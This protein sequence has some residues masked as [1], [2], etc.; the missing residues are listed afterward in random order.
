[1]PNGVESAYS[2][3]F[4]GPD[5]TLEIRSDAR[6]DVKSLLGIEGKQ[7]SDFARYPDF[8]GAREGL[9]DRVTSS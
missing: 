3:H 2:R 7:V 6:H 5:S 4:F 1:M 9:V 8:S